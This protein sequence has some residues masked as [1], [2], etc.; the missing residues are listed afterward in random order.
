MAAIANQQQQQKICRRDRQRRA[1]PILRC[2]NIGGTVGSL[3][4]RFRIVV[5]LAASPC[6][7]GG[8]DGDSSQQQCR[9]GTFA[10]SSGPRQGE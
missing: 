5:W 8:P 9:G 10:A 1:A 4:R 2:A 6:G 7:T 3:R